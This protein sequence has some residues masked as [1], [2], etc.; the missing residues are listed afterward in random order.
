MLI[1]TQNID[2][3]KYNVTVKESKC[4]YFLLMIKYMKNVINSKANVHACVETIY[5]LF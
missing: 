5:T 3:S 2:T 1:I 4:L